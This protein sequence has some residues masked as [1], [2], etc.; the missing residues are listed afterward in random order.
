[1]VLLLKS[2]EKERFYEERRNIKTT[3][4]VEFS[5][6]W[7]DLKTILDYKIKR[8]KPKDQKDIKNIK[9]YLEENSKIK[10]RSNSIK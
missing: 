10:K 4:R 6:R 3:W 8:N 7:I 5:K 1:M 2:N 9:K